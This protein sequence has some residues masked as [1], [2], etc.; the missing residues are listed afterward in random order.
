MIRASAG[1]LVL[2]S[3]FSLGDCRACRS[4]PPP[5]L[6]P[7]SDAAVVPEGELEDASEVSDPDAATPRTLGR[8]APGDG[9]TLPVEPALAA[10]SGARFVEYLPIESPTGEVQGVLATLKPA[11][12]P[13]TA[14]YFA[15][16]ATGWTRVTQEGLDAPDPQC[17]VQG[18]ESYD[19]RAFS[20][21][22]TQC[23]GAV[24]SDGGVSTVLPGA[25]VQEAMAFALSEDGRTLRG[26]YRVAEL[27]P[28]LPNTQLD[29]R[30]SYVRRDS[31]LAWDLAVQVQVSRGDD[32][33]GQGLTATVALLDRG[34]GFARDLAEPAA[35]LGRIVQA[36]AGLA[37]SRRRAPEALA[38]IERA[39]RLRRVLCVEGASPR[40]RLGSDLGV[41]CGT[42]L[43]S[44][45]SQEARALLTLGELPAVEALQWSETASEFGLVSSD[46]IDQELQR[47]MG[48]E[49]GVT[50]RSGPYLGSAQDEWLVRSAMITLDPPTRPT[51]ALLR[52]TTHARVSFASLALE[53]GEEGSQQELFLRSPDGRWVAKGAWQSCDGVVVAL[54]PSSDETCV[55]APAL[56]ASPPTGATLA[57]LTSL[58]SADF[59]ARCMRNEAGYEPVRRALD[60]RAVGFAREGLV[61]SW[62]G[63]LMRTTSDFSRFEPI[64]AGQ[65]VGSGFAPGS[66]A[67]ADGRVVA[68][69]GAEGIFVRDAQ[70]RWRAWKPPQLSG[71]FRQ[72]GDLT[73]ASDGSMIA[74]RLGTQLWLIERL[75][76]APIAR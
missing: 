67:S 61:I 60:L 5:I 6:F 44:L 40:V 14:A 53:P 9:L 54:C 17:A 16:A 12:G 69:Q 48:S 56:S 65:P 64:V 34:V 8:R 11:Q 47:A 3:A 20:L 71:R 70:G 36:V 13:A 30:L 42:A 73:V 10:P 33:P 18:L 24:P 50:A 2:A 7:V 45:A 25:V 46:R 58:A 49:T 15:R 51:A 19:P 68:L 35:S 72:L 38:L 23:A 41:R 62:R 75:A 22:F 21:R 27:G 63:R 4:T 26:R 39:Q 59:S 66:A 32:R 76:G 28:S 74:A 29:L 52:G 37:T 1:M 31:D 57:R 55:T 43:D